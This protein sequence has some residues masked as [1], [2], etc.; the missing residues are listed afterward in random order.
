LPGCWL[1]SAGLPHFDNTR[2]LGNPVKNRIDEPDIT[3]HGVT[4]ASIFADNRARR[5]MRHLTEFQRSGT[6]Q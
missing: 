3:A 2:R 4:K 1:G 6:Q 5:Q